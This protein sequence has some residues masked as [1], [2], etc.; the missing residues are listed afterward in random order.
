MTL[1]E[2]KFEEI[3]VTDLEVGDT[4]KLTERDTFSEVVSIEETPVAN[5]T[6]YHIRVASST[7]QFVAHSTSTV[8][9]LT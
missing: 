9:R 3:P 5:R 7:K 6:M 4:I 2:N 1:T 8:E